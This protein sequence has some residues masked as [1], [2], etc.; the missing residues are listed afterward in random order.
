M[1]T[2]NGKQGLSEM[3]GNGVKGE[4]G[5]GKSKKQNKKKGREC[6]QKQGKNNRTNT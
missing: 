6:R 3:N 2:K 5:T 1:N 4:V